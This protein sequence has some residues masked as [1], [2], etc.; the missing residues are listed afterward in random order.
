MASN[1]VSLKLR[2]DSTGVSEGLAGITSSLKSLATTMGIAFSAKAIF[3]FG[4]KSID[5]A[6][7]LTESQNVVDV[8]FGKMSS[9][10]NDFASNCLQSFGLSEL[11]AKQFTGTLGGIS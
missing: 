9:Q 11:S 7:D 5:L 2:L 1:D 3:D 4:K 8:T 10:I 6:S